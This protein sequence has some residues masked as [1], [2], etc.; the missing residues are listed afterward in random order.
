M[1]ML[2]TAVFAAAL[3][4]GGSAYAGGTFDSHYCRYVEDA[5]ELINYTNVRM[6]REEVRQ[7]YDH[8]AEVA[9]TQRTIYSASPVFVWASEA[10]VSC[11]QAIGYLRKP[12]KWKRRPNYVTVQKCECFYDRMTQYL[13]R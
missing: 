4:L 13:S 9:T 3:L 1:K 12:W 6:L 8:A 11:A 10:K 7:R 2:R 5:Q